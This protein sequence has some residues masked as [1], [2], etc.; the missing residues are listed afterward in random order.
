MFVNMDFS[1]SGDYE[2]DR[3]VNNPFDDLFGEKSETDEVESDAGGP[4]PDSW[5]PE[6]PFSVRLGKRLIDIVCSVL[7]LIL[8]S[9]IF[10]LIIIAIELTDRG[11]A[12]FVQTRLGYHGRPFR[13]LKFRTMFVGADKIS[14][15][16]YLRMLT[17]EVDGPVFKI[18]DDPRVTRV[19]RFLRR[20]SL[21]E[22]PQLINVLKG[23]MSLVGPRPPIAYEVHAYKSWHLL[24]LSCRPGITGLWQVQRGKKLTFEEMVQLDLTY[25]KNLSILEDLRI[26]VETPRAVWSPYV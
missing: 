13:Y 12:F 9:P 20:T 21:D 25:I 7:F 19:G 23:D 5:L 6:P 26:L 11:P 18:T 14:Q 16:G 1:Y 10:L 24:R 3:D 17:N 15:D 22:L 8:L 4:Q 2:M